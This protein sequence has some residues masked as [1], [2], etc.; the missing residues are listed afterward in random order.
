[1]ATSGAGTI[2]LDQWDGSVASFSGYIG[3]S[4]ALIG[5]NGN[6]SH[7][8]FEF[9]ALGYRDLSVTFFTRGTAT[10]FNTGVWSWSTDGVSF[11]PLP[12]VNTA[13]RDTSFDA[14]G[15]VLVD[16]SEVPA[17]NHAASVTLRYT[18]DGSTSSGGNNR[19]D[20]LVVHATHIPSL[21]VMAAGG[22]A[23]ERN[24][25]PAT[26]IFTTDVPVGESG[27]SVN[28]MVGGSA[29]AGV[30]YVLM[31][32]ANF[33]TSTGAGTVAI[34]PGETSTVLSV[35]PI[36]DTNA[37]EFD[38]T[39][40]MQ[41]D[42]ASGL[43]YFVGASDSAQVVI[44]DDTPY[45]SAWAAR[46]PGFNG[47]PT[48]DSDGNGLVN[49]AESFFDLNPFNDEPVVLTPVRV[50]PV[51]DP[52][53]GATK[54]FATFAYLRRTDTTVLDHAEVALSLGA[55]TEEVVLVSTTPGLDPMTE[56]VKWRGVVPL[57]G[58][59]ATARQFFRVRLTV[60]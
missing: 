49:F 59:G 36:A 17:L 27:L 24:A 52:S 32:V 50:E 51:V 19:L 2:Y 20:E 8:D 11:I 56:I 60:P 44:E 29:T 45:S 18:L 33:N 26:M 21:N 22:A 42:A 3:Q 10:G 41:F 34:P 9:S 5:S 4:L 43:E 30:D 53:D 1:S 25:N 28:F 37:T 35:V 40:T 15:E 14:N 48:A 57:D 54:T 7:I 23:K 55:W 58:A 12:G 39:V 46:F 6:G 13:T 47:A 31:G 16:F 38:E